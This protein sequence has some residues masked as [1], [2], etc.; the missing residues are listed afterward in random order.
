MAKITQL[1]TAVGMAVAPA[2]ATGVS[3]SLAAQ[4]KP[5]LEILSKGY[6]AASWRCFGSAL[7][8]LVI[9]LFGLND[10]GRVGSA[11]KVEG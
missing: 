10:I 6:I 1:G 9:C 5:K 2:I 7:T 4:H 3:N 11:K 8:A